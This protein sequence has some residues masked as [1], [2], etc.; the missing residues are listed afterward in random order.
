[1]S[2]KEQKRDIAPSY[3][4]ASQTHHPRLGSTLKGS[5]SWIV[6]PTIAMVVSLGV[7]LPMPARAQTALT[8]TSSGVAL[9]DYGGATNFD[10]AS[11]VTITNGG[12]AVYGDTTNSWTLSN[13]G[14]IDGT[15]SGVVF[16]GSNSST[17]IN[18]GA[19][20]GGGGTA[21]QFGTGD[22]LLEIGA[23]ASFTGVADGG[24][25]ND[26]IEFISGANST[27]SNF[28]GFDTVA[29]DS[30]ATWTNSATLTDIAVT[31]AGSFVNAGTITN[32]TG[33]AVT[34]TGSSYL[35]LRHHHRPHNRR[36]RRRRDTNRCQHRQD[37][38]DKPIR[39]D[40]D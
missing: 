2:F 23:G 30:G 29:I 32:S 3:S 6:V 21:V 37:H 17:L 39:R 22:D 4:Y 34:L 18:R 8:T 27:F 10:V 9:A 19:I 35:Q 28:T 14:S 26:E 11:G 40:S 38:G 13:E 5:C 16:A 24:A 12:I 15:T 31:D 1:M 25:G 33:N 7:T 36:S 20:A